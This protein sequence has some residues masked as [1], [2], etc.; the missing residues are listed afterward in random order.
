QDDARGASWV[1]R[2]GSGPATRTVTVVSAPDV[3][4]SPRASGGND[5][6]LPS[7]QL[8]GEIRTAAKIQRGDEPSQARARKGWKL[9]GAYQNAI[10]RLNSVVD[11]W[12]V[13]DP[14]AVTKTL[15][16]VSR[17]KEFAQWAAQLPELVEEEVLQLMSKLPYSP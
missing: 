4:G 12:E 9:I 3:C 10:G 14:N 7:R 5:G 2:E 17:D 11:L 16:A 15:A 1:G 6:L 13:S 8:E